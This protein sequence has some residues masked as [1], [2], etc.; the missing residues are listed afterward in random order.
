M[1]AAIDDIH[2]RDGQNT[3]ISP[4]NIA[5]ERGLHG[6]GH[7][8]GEGKR[9]TEGGICAEAGFIFCAVKLDE[10]LVNAALVL[11]LKAIKRVSNFSIDVQNCLA[12]AFAEIAGFIAIAKLNRFMR[13]C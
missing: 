9:D 11:G 2:H 7:G 13:A 12:N 1:L 10:E 5:V 6:I 4:A 3:C 8:F